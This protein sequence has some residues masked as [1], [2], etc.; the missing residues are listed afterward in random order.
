MIHSTAVIEKG[1]EVSEN[2][3]IG[4][5]SVIGPNVKIAKGT[6][7]QSHVT[8]DGHTTIGED[9][10]F[11]P[12]ATIGTAPQDLSYKNEPTEL[13]IGNRNTFREFVSIN[14]GTTK[15]DHKTVIG[16]ENLVM[17]YSHIGHDAMIG[18]KVRIVNSCNLAGHV[19]IKD[20]VI[21]SGGCNISQFITL[22]EGS[23]IGGGSGIDRDI[24]CYSTAYGNRIKL[25]GI[26]I[27]GLKRSGIDKSQISEIVDFYRTM[28]SSALSP[29][30]Y[31]ESQEVI[32]E[33]G[34]NKII[35]EMME[36]IS[37]SK[38]GIP[39]FMS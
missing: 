32:A 28:E 25:K 17:A 2:V 13:I 4:A 30:S 24:P 33:Y 7:I 16:D 5:Y 37:K 3:S 8:I 15:V 11:F 19:T 14:R 22:G 9:N 20:K 38:V 27:I 26:N 29:R 10:I 36:F 31:V 35:K 23:F 12:H 1:A 39:P 34:N 21:I 18:N 6:E